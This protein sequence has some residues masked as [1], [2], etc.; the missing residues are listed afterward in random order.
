MSPDQWQPLVQVLDLS[1]SVRRRPSLC[2]TRYDI[3]LSRIDPCTLV[4]PCYMLVTFSFPRK[5]SHM[6]FSV[7]AT[8]LF[9]IRCS[10]LLRNTSIFA[11]PFRALS[12]HCSLS[13]PLVY[14]PRRFSSS[15]REFTKQGRPANPCGARPRLHKVSTAS[16]SSRGSDRFLSA[17]LPISTTN[18][19]RASL[20]VQLP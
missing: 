16:T 13:R 19:C 20:L 5:N 4:A 12:T 1:L 7:F 6:S 9:D 2:D 17:C 11:F 18:F 15:N 8:D 10:Q 14:P 3:F